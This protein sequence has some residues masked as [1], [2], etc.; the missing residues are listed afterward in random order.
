MELNTNMS[1][2]EMLNVNRMVNEHNII[3]NAAN[4]RAAKQSLGKD[5]FLT[6]LIAQLQHQ[7]PSNP[8]ENTDF[9]AQMAQFSTL[10]QMSNVSA[11]FDKLADKLNN[12]EA[13]SMLG[14]TVELGLGESVV[15]GKVESV[16]RGEQPEVMVNGGMYGMHYIKKIIYSE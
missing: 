13:F 12:S 14:K 16:T 4:G 7:D 3:N 10:E 5:D 11:G 9:I 15:I 2:Q 8:M 6:L 1:P